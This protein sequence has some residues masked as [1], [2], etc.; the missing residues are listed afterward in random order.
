MFSPHPSLCPQSVLGI[1]LCALKQ[2]E[3]DPNAS[4]KF[5][6]F[7]ADKHVSIVWSFLVNNFI[8][9][10]ISHCIIFD[11]EL[12]EEDDRDVTVTAVINT[13]K[14]SFDFKNNMHTWCWEIINPFLR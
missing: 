6:I 5:T 8:L 2:F 1:Q 4:I 9:P 11:D 14:V 3:V 13:K 7:V 12:Y 10:V